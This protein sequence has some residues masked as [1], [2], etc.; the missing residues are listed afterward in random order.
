MR[1]V[2]T[3]AKQMGQPQSCLWGR[4]HIGA[5]GKIWI[6]VLRSWQVIGINQIHGHCCENKVVHNQRMSS[7]NHEWCQ[8]QLAMIS[9]IHAHPN[10]M[11]AGV[12]DPHHQSR[13]P[14]KGSFRLS[15]Q[16]LREAQRERELQEAEWP[17]PYPRIPCQGYSRVWCFYLRKNLLRKLE[18]GI[19]N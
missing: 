7:W 14:E 4:N 12:V 19:P 18:S 5:R 9:Q 2:C 10:S 3:P 11:L 6:T 16:H 15:R 1:S 13:F 8:L 17:N